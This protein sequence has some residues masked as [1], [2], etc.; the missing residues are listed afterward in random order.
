MAAWPNGPYCS[1]AEAVLGRGRGRFAGRNGPFCNPLS[2]RR[3][4]RPVPTVTMFYGN[5]P[6]VPYQYSF[7]TMST[8]IKTNRY[9]TM[10]NLLLSLMAM[11]FA[12]SAA[13]ESVCIN[14][15]WQFRYAPGPR[16]ADSIA[17]SGFYDRSARARF[18]HGQGA[19]VLGRAGLRGARLPR[20][21]GRAPQRRLLPQALPRAR[22]FAG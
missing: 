16:Q 5:A 4:R 8:T 2:P 10:R 1:A 9:H 13:Q 15:D 11:S 19:V 18:H 12:V 14:G 7:I 17:A 20:V 6:P 21:Q 3:L 22:S